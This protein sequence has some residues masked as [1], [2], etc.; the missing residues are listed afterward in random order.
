MEY[1]TVHNIFKIFFKRI[2]HS[3]FDIQ[4]SHYS[5][6]ISL[7]EVLIAI[8]IFTLSV[9]A[10]GTVGLSGTLMAEGSVDRYRGVLLAK[11]GI[12]A[13]RSIRAENFSQLTPGTYG[14]TFSGGKWQLSLS[15]D[16]TDKFSRTITIAQVG[17]SR[18]RASVDVT[19][20]PLGGKSGSIH[21]A[22]FIDQLYG[23][24]WNQTT[25]VDFSGGKLNGTEAS[26]G[27][28]A[29]QLERTGDWTKPKE[30]LTYDMSDIGTV[31]SMKEADGVLY[32]ASTGAGS[33]PLVAL[34]LGDAGQGVL[35][36]LASVDVGATV[37]AIAVV[38]D[39]LCVGT[40]DDARE[41][42]VLKRKDLSL[43]RT[44][45]LTG[46]ADT[47]SLYASGTMLYLGR[48][49]STQPELYQLDVSNPVAGIPTVRSAN[50]VANVTALS[51]TAQY[52][53]IGSTANAGEL[54]VVRKSDLV[55]ANTLDLSGTADVTSLLVSG[56]DLYISRT[57]SAA[58]E[59][60]RVDVATPLSPLSINGGVDVSTTVRAIALGSDGRLYAATSQAASEV[61]A[62]P[63]PSLAPPST[64]NVAIGNG[65][66]SILAVGPYVY[67]GMENNNP[68][69]VVL[70]GGTGQCA[71]PI[72]QGSYDSAG[73]IDGSAVTVK[74]NYAYLGTL[75]NGGGAEFS[76]IDISDKALPV[77]VGSLEINA[78]V[79]GISVLGPYAYLATSDN[80]R[81]F[82]VVNIANPV[83]PFIAGVYN[84]P[85]SVD[86]LSVAASGTLAILGTKNNGSA[87]ELYLLNVSN[88]GT[89]S[90][91]AAAEVG[92]DV[93]DAVFTSNGYVV[94]ASSNDAKELVVFDSRTPGVLP[95]VA[96]YNTVGNPD[97]LGVAMFGVANA[98]I[99]LTTQTGGTWNFYIFTLNLSNG[100]VAQNSFLTLT[101]NGYGVAVA[102]G[103]A[104]IANDQS[105]NGLA[106]VDV[107]NLGAP[108]LVGSLALGARVNAVATDGVYAYLSSVDNNREFVVGAPTPLSLARA[109]EGWFTSSTFDAGIASPLWGT[110]TW[111]ATGTGS[112][113]MQVRTSSTQAGLLSAFWVGSGGVH[114]GSYA[115]SGGVV[116]PDAGAD[117]LEWIQYRIKLW[118]D[119]VT[120]PIVTDVTITYN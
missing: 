89:P 33:D 74:G 66:R 52:L 107:G 72:V 68:E 17:T 78:N 29:T 54:Y 119:M 14:L 10:L 26:V 79:N 117:G 98:N 83:N 46:S 5:R 101:G 35:T 19:W 38:G 7:I 3:T 39:Y 53:F 94:A 15:P 114:G 18:L 92:A 42:V 86:A 84:A 55:T 80:N 108:L 109:K 67:V 45:D 31:Y 41:L 9:A 61:I 50:F 6:G 63:T 118:G 76:V 102:N 115:T 103:F 96:S 1:R 111:Q 4:S 34:D 25:E 43:V 85:G 56:N 88:P 57:Q 81:E 23:A 73:S 27:D 40:N 65:A 60:V 51:G 16:S 75:V 91:S 120:T 28:G 30:F 36:Q 82:I 104:F 59:V 58:Q 64:Y 20:A 44:L 70:R 11:E 48:V 47:L 110:L 87:G 90:L 105:G 97:G 95:E 69:L 106:I 93:N 112:T 113:S 13:L 49:Q 2:R 99:A 37:N 77:R 32:V 21:A 24:Q 12:E 22:T 8:A 62:Y 100:S 71:N 116:T